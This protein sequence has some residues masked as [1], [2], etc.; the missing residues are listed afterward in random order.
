[1]LPFPHLRSRKLYATLEYV[2][3]ARDPQEPPTNGE[4]RPEQNIMQGSG[5]MFPRRHF[6]RQL[7]E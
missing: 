3:M 7:R 1:M 4:A 2:V 6:S 5:Y